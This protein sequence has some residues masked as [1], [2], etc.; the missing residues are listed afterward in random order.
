M[1]LSK[2]VFPAL[3]L[4]ATSMSIVAPAFAQ[5]GV[6]VLTGT[7]QDAATK[8]PIADV[9]VTVTSPSM[10]GEQIVVTDASG[11]YRIP[12]LPSGEFTL[13]LEKETYKPYARPNIGLRSDVTIRVDAQLL[14]EAIQSEEV[15]VVGRAPTVD[16]GSSTTG[17]NI[18]SDFTRRIPV[19]PPAGKGGAV[20]S[21]ESVAEVTPGANADAY[22]TSI[23]GTTSPENNY[24]IDGLTVNNPALGIIG[25]PLSTEFV[26]EVNV[27]SGGYMPEYGRST[28]GILSA[29]TK[30][31]SNDFRGSAWAFFSPGALEGAR[32]TVKTIGS[33]IQ[34]KTRLFYSGDVGFDVG[35]PIVK[36]K[37]WFYAGA[38]ISRS[39]YRLDRTLNV[40][41]F[42]PDGTPALNDDKSPQ[43]RLIP[44]T[45]QSFDAVSTALQLF[46]KLTYTLNENNKLIL[47]VI[48]T[49]TWSGGGGDYAIDPQQG[50]PEATNLIGQYSALAHKLSGTGFDAQLRWTSERDNKRLLFDTAVGWHHE[51]GGTRPS[52]GS[53]VGSKDGLAGLSGVT[54]RRSPGFHSINDFEKLPD[55]TVCDPAG[56]AKAVLCPVK[57]YLTGGPGFLDDITLERY[58]ARHTMTYLATGAGHHVIKAGIDIEFM[59]YDHKKAYSGGDYY[60]EATNGKSFADYRQYG[61][62]TAPDSPFVLNTLRWKTDAVTVGGFIQDSWSIM[63][64][65]TLNVGVRY[66]AQWVYGGQGTLALALP[67]QWSPRAGLIWD[68]T[69]EGRAKIFGNYAR[70]YESVPLDIADRAGSSEPQIQSSHLKSSCDPT[71]PLQQ[72][73]ACQANTNRRVINGSES[74][75]Q[76]WVIT[77]AGKTPIDPNIKPQ[78]SDELVFGGEYEIFKD[79]RAGVSYTRRWMNNVI[80]DMSRDEAQ[81][82][83]V[84]NPGSGIASDFPKAER[85]YDGVTAYFTK[86]F[87]DLWLA[88]LSYTVSYLRGNYAGL[89]RPETQQLDPNINSD[90][91]LRSLLAN[92]TG[93]LPG[94]HTHSIKL[95]G[96]RDIELPSS[97][98]LNVGGSFRAR[99]GAPTDYLG[100]HPL[101]GP[102]EVFI[103]PRGAG[104]RLPWRYDVDAHLGYGVKLG[105]EQ[106]LTISVDVFNLLN[107][108]APTG[109]D[110]RYTASDVLPIAN[111]TKASLPT[112]K[113]TDGSPFVPTD[114]TAANTNPNFG[115]TTAYQ[116]PRTFRFGIRTTF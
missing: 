17:L 21:F 40:N 105:K 11:Q 5:Q 30:S 112:L 31:G 28:G 32:T 66:D 101:Y 10:Q 23:N 108:Q 68:P 24:V 49:P 63:D 59:A 82:Y 52:D 70:L 96:A 110:S 76:R 33:T 41:V 98:H 47:T 38:D 20:R 72:Q 44:G 104:E 1:T 53:A 69:Q 4:V 102:D 19:S 34:T 51:S 3:A 109:K 56:T 54:W 37:L 2:R 93:P 73:G 25:T 43:T 74:P 6:A 67:N 84:G 97:M 27:L 22:G 116:E 18:S 78:S 15:V 16:V 26:G 111:G 39:V 80:E 9:V 95:Y 62:L 103:L 94:D 89:F 92:R 7:V 12:N 14:P 88:Q 87:A 115:N 85:N 99:S 42:N 57:T 107:F 91:D 83:F 61:F 81:T 29:V 65:V 77:G 46:G 58:Q 114:G 75:D 50:G 64:K 86:T 79:G 100:S 36:D 60:R 48:G 113:N 55:P 35:G 90:F 45:A 71:D 106:T 13:R 8:Q